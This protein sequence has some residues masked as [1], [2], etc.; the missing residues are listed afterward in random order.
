MAINDSGRT[1]APRGTKNITQA[2]FEALDGIAEGQQAAVA[3]AAL[4][5]IRDELKERR[6]KAKEAAGRAKAKAPAKTSAKAKAP[7]KASAKAK[8]PA[9]TRTAAKAK[10]PAAGRA[11]AAAPK[12]P[13]VAARK[14]APAKVAPAK[15]KLPAK[16]TKAKRPVETAPVPPPAE[17]E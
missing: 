1:R 6:V 12:A 11:K 8:V 15:R 9:K 2:F 13:P 4:A 10:A 16:T 5:S 7:A 3:T 14:Q 17:T